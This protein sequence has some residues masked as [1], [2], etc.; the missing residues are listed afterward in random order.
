MY[1]IVYSYKDINIYTHGLL[2]VL[3]AV[4]GGIIIYYL[5]KKNKYRTDF[6]F[7]LLLYSFLCGL[8]G[9]RILFD[10]LYFDQFSNYYEIFFIW[11]GG[12]TLFGGII[13]GIITAYFLLKKQ[14]E[15]IYKWFD[16]GIIGILVGLAIGRIGSF[17][18]GDSAGISSASILS[19][20]GKYPTQLFESIWCIILLAFSFV[21]FK[22]KNKFNLPDG[23]VF[24]FGIITYCLGRLFIDIL[25][26][27]KTIFY[28]IKLSQIAAFIFVVIFSI[29]LV[30][31]IK[32]RRKN[33]Y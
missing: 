12:F 27:D 20:W 21:I 18:S 22:F 7:D 19:I 15:N 29:M 26:D 14:K 4:V 9:A 1:P 10:I 8:I 17:L 6:L 28:F 5:A 24:Y 16:I 32:N 13:A 3:G 30:K 33:G 31:L 25:R 11:T 23:A 2:L